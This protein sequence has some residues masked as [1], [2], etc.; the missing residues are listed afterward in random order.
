MI[1][2]TVG[3]VQS[4]R[5]VAAQLALLVR[6]RCQPE[7]QLLAPSHCQTNLCHA[8]L[9]SAMARCLLRTSASGMP[10]SWSIRA[11]RCR[12]RSSSPVARSP[13]GARGVW[14]RCS[15][16]PVHAH[17][18]ICLST[19]C[20][21][22]VSLLEDH[23]VKSVSAQVCT[24]EPAG[25]SPRQVGGHRNKEQLELEECGHIVAIVLFTCIRA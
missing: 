8:V 24:L 25:R 7:F 12:L 9:L 10:A 3:L 6:K 15:D 4:A 22:S 18:C 11:S 19:R 23:H 5:P 14:A 16:S 17:P 20:A 13:I 21:A 2:V 1:V